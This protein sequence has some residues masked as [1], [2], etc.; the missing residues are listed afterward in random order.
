MD[1]T[2]QAI[3]DRCSTEEEAPPSRQILASVTILLP[4]IQIFS[5]F[6]LFG[7]EREREEEGTKFSLVWAQR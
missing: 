2:F 6:K 4:D 1:E 3:P 5:A 7:E